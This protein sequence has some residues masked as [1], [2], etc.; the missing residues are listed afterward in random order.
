VPALDTPP[1]I[2]RIGNQATGEPFENKGGIAVLPG[3]DKLAGSLFPLEHMVRVML[4]DTDAS[5]ADVIR[6][7]TLTP[8]ERVGLSADR[9]SLEAGKLADIIVLS[10][11]LQTQ[12]TFI[13]GEEFRDGV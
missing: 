6:M 3:T 4:R 2:Y 11:Q 9:G 10:P 13:G 1:G 8:A 7:A 12:R 5:M